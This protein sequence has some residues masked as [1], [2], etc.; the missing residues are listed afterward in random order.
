MKN[1]PKRIKEINL[2]LKLVINKET[3]LDLLS[4]QKTAI[5]DL[6]VELNKMLVGISNQQR[7]ALKHQ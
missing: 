1:L 4:K 7:D 6:Q 2:L 5:E 3:R